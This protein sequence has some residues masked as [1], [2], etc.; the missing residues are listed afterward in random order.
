MYMFKNNFDRVKIFLEIFQSLRNNSHV[1][2]FFKFIFM[3]LKIDDK[4]KS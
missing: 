1:H 3:L 2:Y 4:K